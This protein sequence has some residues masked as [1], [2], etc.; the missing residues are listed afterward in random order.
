MTDTH[1]GSDRTAAF[2]GLI[3]GIVFLLA[4]VITV[5]KLTTRSFAGHSTGKATASA[6]R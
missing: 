3:V 2:T 1:G 6:V 4:V 5:S